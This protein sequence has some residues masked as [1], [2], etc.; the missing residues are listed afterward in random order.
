MH[1]FW[2]LP[3]LPTLKNYESLNLPLIHSFYMSN[4][5]PYIYFVLIVVI[6]TTIYVYRFR[7]LIAEMK[8]IMQKIK[9][10]V[11]TGHYMWNRICSLSSLV[12]ITNSLTIDR[13]MHQVPNRTSVALSSPSNFCYNFALPLSILY[14]ICIVQHYFHLILHTYLSKYLVKITS[15][16]VHERCSVSGS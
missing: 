13:K 15:K 4:I 10:S 6:V 9:H 5:H 1:V 14:F 16:N 2:Y 11:V 8:F 12:I 3:P 7:L